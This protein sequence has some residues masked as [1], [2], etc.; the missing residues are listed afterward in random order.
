ML[1]A[2]IRHDVGDLREHQYEAEQIL[3]A[4]DKEYFTGE[5]EKE[6]EKL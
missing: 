2:F 5:W 4:D 1:F 6:S 3:F